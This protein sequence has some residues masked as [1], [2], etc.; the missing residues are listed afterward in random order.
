MS[1]E[2][3]NFKD[4]DNKIL[5]LDDEFEIMTLLKVALQ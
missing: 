4:N 3:M 2:G 5:I 1:N